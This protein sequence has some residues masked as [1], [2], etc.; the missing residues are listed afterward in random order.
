M[1][2]VELK[3]YVFWYILGKFFD[4]PRSILHL[5]TRVFILGTAG[6]HTS[7]IVLIRL[8]HELGRYV[9]FM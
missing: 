5:S 6:V 3:N 8:R 2:A 7:I 4:G 1:Q 9:D